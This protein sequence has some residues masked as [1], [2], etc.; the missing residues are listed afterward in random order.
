MA[1]IILM[2]LLLAVM[3]LTLHV[4]QPI[5]EAIINYFLF[6]NGVLSFVVEDTETEEWQN[7]QQY[8]LSL[9]KKPQKDDN[10]T[11][12]QKLEPELPPRDESPLILQL[13]P[14]FQEGGALNQNQ[15][16]MGDEYTGLEIKHIIQKI[17]QQIDE[18]TF[19]IETIY[20]EEAD[21]FL[22]M[23]YHNGFWELEDYG[24]NETYQTT[25]IVRI[26][27][28]SAEYRYEFKVDLKTK[29]I[30]SIS[31]VLDLQDD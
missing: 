16:I 24:I 6:H 1:K 27:A 13:D 26:G 22:I 23:T 31:K 3:G 30:I 18:S 21:T 8:F 19:E 20:L 7:R 11:T 2:S 4:F 9:P 15:G 10:P 28:R 29:E 25:Q 5:S 14:A 12:P 17:K